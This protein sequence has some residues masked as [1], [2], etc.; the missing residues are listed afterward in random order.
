M[1][2]FEYSR[3]ICCMK[4]MF[5]SSRLLEQ[6][7]ARSFIRSGNKKPLHHG[8]APPRGPPS[9]TAGVP[10]S[11]KW[12]YSGIHKAEHKSQ[13]HGGRPAFR[14]MATKNTLRPLSSEKKVATHI[15]DMKGS[16]SRSQKNDCVAG[17]TMRNKD[18]G[19]RRFQGQKLLHARRA[20]FKAPGC[21]K[22]PN[23]HLLAKRWRKCKNL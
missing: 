4:G 22:N 7:Q 8:V 10:L 2:V 16:T 18:R 17:F 19:I 6:D 21:R 14:K 3:G 12:L 9:E 20:K 1:T 23:S 13:K 5:L 15:L 11:G